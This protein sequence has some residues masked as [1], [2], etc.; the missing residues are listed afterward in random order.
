MAYTTHGYWIPGTAKVDVVEQ[1]NAG[2]VVQCGGIDG[3]RQ[4]FDEY[5]AYIK[6]N[7][8]PSEEIVPEPPATKRMVSLTVT[9]KTEAEWQ[10]IHSDLSH[11]ATAIGTKYGAVTV[12]SQSLD[13]LYYEETLEPTEPEFKL[14]CT[15][16]HVSDFPACTRPHVVT[17]EDLVVKFD[18]LLRSHG[19]NAETAETIF[20][21]M[22]MIGIGLNETVPD[23]RT[24][25]PWADDK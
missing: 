17:N 2:L 5:N 9:T 6:A 14:E 4:C 11:L 12:S 13:D 22:N 24:E 16:M 20:A 8:I 3:C 21:A 25:D 7:P 23:V 1:L 19:V 15:R 10:K 18:N